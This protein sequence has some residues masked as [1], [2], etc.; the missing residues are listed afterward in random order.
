MSHH[1]HLGHQVSH[2]IT[3][4]KC[5]FANSLDL[6][7]QPRPELLAKKL[8]PNR[9]T[10]PSGKKSSPTAQNPRTDGKVRL[11]AK[12][13]FPNRNAVGK[14]RLLAKPLRGQTVPTPSTSPTASPL[15]VGKGSNPSPRGLPRCWRTAFFPISLIVL[16]MLLAKNFH[17]FRILSSNFFGSL[18]TL[19]T[20]TWLNVGSF[21]T[22]S[23]IS[24]IIF[25]HLNFLA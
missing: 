3:T 20:S 11:L 2:L 21:A 4:G 17:F 18:A 10:L 7:Q 5:G 12:G 25:I 15:A 6:S 1:D 13:F 22:F 16:C 24:L 14:E 8:F 19:F 9:K 23:Y